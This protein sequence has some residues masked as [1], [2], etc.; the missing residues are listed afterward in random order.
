MSEDSGV[1]LLQNAHDTIHEQAE[2]I[3]ILQGTVEVLEEK[4]NKTQSKLEEEIALRKQWEIRAKKVAPPVRRPKR[5]EAQLNQ[6]G[7][8][9]NEMIKEVRQKTG[10]GLIEVRRMLEQFKWDKDRLMLEMFSGPEDPTLKE[11]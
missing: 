1:T 6:D 3:K 5:N 4:L 8:K 2:F 11:E 7:Q 9:K 10:L